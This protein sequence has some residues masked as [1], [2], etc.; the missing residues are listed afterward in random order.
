LIN[1]A[2]LTNVDAAE[3]FPEKATRLNQVGSR[4]MA[5]VAKKLKIPLVQIFTEYVFSGLSK[6][7]WKTHGKTEPMSAYGLSKL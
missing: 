5:R 3:E 7:P 6:Q 1:C 4:N 2:A